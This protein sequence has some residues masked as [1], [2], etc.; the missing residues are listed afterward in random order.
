MR[1]FRNPAN[2]GIYIVK[3]GIVGSVDFDLPSLFAAEQDKRFHIHRFIH[4]PWQQ[5]ADR[6]HP[7]K[8]S[9]RGTYGAPT[10]DLGPVG[11]ILLKRH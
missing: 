5:K 3:K 2:Q 4:R 1:F 8:A 11:K 6:G 7:R 9:G 10:T